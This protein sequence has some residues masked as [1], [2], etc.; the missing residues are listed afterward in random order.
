MYL[1]ILISYRC[2]LF[3]MLFVL[4]LSFYFFFRRSVHMLCRRDCSSFFFF[5]FSSRRRHTRCS[6]DWSSDVCSSDLSVPPPDPICSSL[7]IW[8]KY[9][10]W[11]RNGQRRRSGATIGTADEKINRNFSAITSTR[12]I[13]SPRVAKRSEERRVGKRV[14]LGGRRIIKKK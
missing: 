12:P 13:N 9:W 11:R 1:V 10:V 14:D 6:S 2:C 4:F 7:S 8:R 5:F 3:A